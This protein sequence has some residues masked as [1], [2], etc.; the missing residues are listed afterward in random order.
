M[1]NRLQ[2]TPRLV[3]IPGVPAVPARA[4]YCITRQVTSSSSG[5][6]FFGGGPD[7]GAYQPFGDIPEGWSG[8][9]LEGG[10]GSSF[11]SLRPVTRTEQACYPGVIGKPAIE[12]RMDQLDHV[13]WTAGGRSVSQVPNDGYF[14][15]SLPGSPVGVQVG[16][17]GRQLQHN[18]AD[19]KHS[20]VARRETFSIVE[21]GFTV[22]GPG[23]LPA[24][25]QVEIRRGRGVVT[26]WVNGAQ[27]YES[28]VS[29]A[30][31]AYAGVVLYSVGDFVDSP[32]IESTIAP[33]SFG[34]RLPALV[35]AISDEGGQNAML[36][37][38]PA[39][40]LNAQLD[41]VAGAASFSIVMPALVV[42][43]SEAGGINRM[44]GTL[45]SLVLTATLGL[46]EE[47]PSSMIAI[48]PP[49]ILSTV[50]LAG[51]S[52]SFSAQLAPMIA[53][54]A[55]A[56]LN[57]VIATMP[58]RLMANIVEPYMPAGETDGS[59]AM[60]LNETA[61]LETALLLIAMDSLEASST[62]ATLTLILELSGLDSLGVSSDASI[63]WVV[64][65]LALEQVAIVSRAGAARQQALQYAVNFMTG[66]L[67]TYRDFDFLGFT[68]DDGHAYGWRKDGLYRLG[69]EGESGDVIRALVDFG[70]SDYGDAHRKRMS[71]AFVGVR[72]DGDCYLR[73]CADSGPEQVYRLIGTEPQKRALL[74]KGVTGRTWNVR[75][76]LTDA[77]YASVDN[78][79]LEVGVSQRRGYGR[80]K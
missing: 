26:Y 25:A 27:V 4:P 50:G 58:T 46:A 60:F 19:M 64:E 10:Y 73:L 7:S 80:G 20:L 9:K 30:G 13:G 67:T 32:R 76:E 71:T 36:G 23:V 11:S 51:Q 40:H 61:V 66:A 22:F 1:A 78:I 52:I 72:T 12:A 65:M 39:I 15:C 28:G 63:G 55:D 2:R 34:A 33:V 17:C 57:R 45:P 18:Y 29:S 74:A 75:L 69:V 47:I 35:A 31:E 21:S 79:E 62:Q 3:Y 59:D 53:A 70:A 54:V 77:S 38:L 14:Q 6:L 56:P 41:P 5:G 68:Y 48:M 42:A 8:V 43:I 37:R 24:G 16:L 49:P 44:L